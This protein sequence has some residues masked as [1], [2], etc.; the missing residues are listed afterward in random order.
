M[1]SLFNDYKT[2]SM[3]ECDILGSHI[4]LNKRVVQVWFQNARAKER[5]AR[6]S[7]SADEDQPKNTSTSC[8]ICNVEFNSRTTLQD[9]IFTVGHIAHIKDRAGVQIRGNENDSPHASAET[10]PLE[11]NKQRAKA[12]RDTKKPSAAINGSLNSGNGRSGLTSPALGATGMNQLSYNL[13]YG[14]TSAASLPM[15]CDP[16]VIGTPIPALQ[17][18]QSVMQRIAIEL[19]QG[20]PSTKFTQDGNELQDL[21]S[22]VHTDDF[23]CVRTT[24]TEVKFIDFLAYVSMGMYRLYGNFY[25]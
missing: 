19:S 6:A 10:I 5:K 21:T 23:R 13:M 18:P 14:L 3:T 1:K 16:N 25:L 2:P 17:I 12:V 8:S 15:I 7:S 9:H 4:G 20:K 24:E 11:E 22:K